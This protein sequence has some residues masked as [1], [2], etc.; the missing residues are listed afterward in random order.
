MNSQAIAQEA[1]LVLPHLRIQNANAISSPLTHGFPSITAFA[2]LGW[3]L[4]RKLAA[5]GTG[6][7][8]T[9][10]GVI[11]HSCQE[12][13]NQGY[14]ST[15]CLSRNPVGK[16]GS[17]AAIVE[18]GRIHLD[19]TLVYA[20]QIQTDEQRLA[21][22]R[23][24]G[25][26]QRQALA[27]QIGEL[28]AQGRVAGGSVLPAQPAP[29]R[30]TRPQLLLMEEKPEERARQF[31]RLRRQWLPGFALVGRDDLLQQ[32]WQ[33]LQRQ[34]SAASL[35]DA[36]LELSR[37]NW[38]SHSNEQGEVQWAQDRPAGSGWCVP[39]PVGYGALGDPYPAGSVANARDNST[40][41]CF[42]ESLYSIGQ[43][44]SPH[45]LDD[46][47][48]LLWYDDNQLDQGLYRLRSAYTPPVE[49]T[50]DQSQAAV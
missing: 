14:V 30:S 19:I 39:I 3:A 7:R 5:L 1:L 4:E 35:L 6:L 2:G 47:D 36:W 20:L 29:G 13:V 22:L 38:R 46:V 26:A 23:H 16:D 41:L 37:F 45:R 31:R 34:N 9:A 48:Q 12:Q 25:A 49:Q 27:D 21:L 24:E 42:V 44:I 8:L 33:Q 28:V 40:P 50:S 18:E 11:A 43:W 17:T 32:R 10:T 15:F